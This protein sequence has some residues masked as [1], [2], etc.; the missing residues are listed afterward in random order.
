MRLHTKTKTLNIGHDITSDNAHSV[1]I[2]IHK[3]SMEFKA[4]TS[5]SSHQ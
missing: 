2:K 1:Y 4:R 3:I 5:P